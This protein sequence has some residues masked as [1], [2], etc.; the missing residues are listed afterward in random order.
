ME[1]EHPWSERL[2]ILAVG[3]RDDGKSDMLNSNENPN[4][5][6]R[7]AHSPFHINVGFSMIYSLSNLT[8][9]IV[10][11]EETENMG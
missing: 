2:D 3:M 5:N 10:E 8:D 11:T 9:Y 6:K 4:N 1:T 7:S